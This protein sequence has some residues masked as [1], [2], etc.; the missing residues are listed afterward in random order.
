LVLE[1]ERTWV[2]SK[3][4]TNIVKKGLEIL[5]DA[6]KEYDLEVNAQVTELMITFPY[7][8]AGKKVKAKVEVKVRLFLCFFN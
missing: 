2:P 6:S 7:Q 5:P 4:K 8:N 3:E 1:A